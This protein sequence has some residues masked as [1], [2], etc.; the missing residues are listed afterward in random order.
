MGENVPGKV[1]YV[2]CQVDKP[3]THHL[4]VADVGH[5]LHVGVATDA[6]CTAGTELN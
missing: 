3:G 6:T 2:L 4:T 5:H 1:A